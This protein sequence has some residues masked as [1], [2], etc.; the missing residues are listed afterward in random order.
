MKQVTF[1]GQLRAA[2]PTPIDTST[3]YEHNP[4]ISKTD[5]QG[6]QVQDW[7]IVYR[8]DYVNSSGGQMRCALVTWDGQGT[9]NNYALTGTTPNNEG[10]WSVSSPTDAGRVYLMVQTRYNGQTGLSEIHGTAFGQS[11]GVLMPDTRILTSPSAMAL[12]VVSPDVDCDGFRFAVGFNE[13]WNASPL[14]LDVWF[15]TFGVTNGQIY[16]HDLDSAARSTGVENAPSI[17]AR[18]GAGDGHIHGAVWTHDLSATSS[19]IESQNYDGLGAGGTNFRVTGCGGLTLSVSGIPQLGDQITFSLNG[20]GLK[21]FVA[22]APV[23][24][25]LG[26]CPGC[27]QGVNGNSILVGQLTVNIPWNAAL[28]GGVFAFQGYEFTVGG[29]CLGQLKLSDTCDVTVR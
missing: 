7:A 22:G 8:R 5:G 16:R 3:D 15:A 18:R 24:A 2:A 21:G 17:V 26:I 4:V 28:V 13:V 23:S 25:P 10:S 1:D 6:V 9:N 27:T 20:N 29:P 14:D 19:R 11:G 12:S